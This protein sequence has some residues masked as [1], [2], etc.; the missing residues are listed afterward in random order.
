MTIEE[1][2]TEQNKFAKKLMTDEKKFFM[3]LKMEYYQFL[4]CMV[5]KLIVVIN[6]QTLH[7]HLKRQSL[8]VLGANKRRAKRHRHEFI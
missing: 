6:N 3:R 1:A 4:K 8:E 2:E 5:R 7:V